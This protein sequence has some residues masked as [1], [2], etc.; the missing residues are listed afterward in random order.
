MAKVD[1]TIVAASLCT[2][3]SARFPEITKQ[4]ERNR[5]LPYLQMHVLADWVAGLPGDL[6]STEVIARVKDFAAWCEI[7]PR[8]ENAGSDIFTIFTVGFFEKIFKERQ[9]R[10]LVPHLVSKDPLIASADYLRR[11]VEEDDYNAVLALYF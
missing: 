4:V 2:E 1:E 10:A 7:Q 5:E 3:L 8:S 9:S 11:W 6:P